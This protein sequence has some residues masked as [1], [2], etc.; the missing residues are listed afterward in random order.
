MKTILLSLFVFLSFS[1]LAQDLAGRKII[2][3]TL[4]FSYFSERHNNEGL[5]MNTSVLYGKIKEDHTYWALGGG[6]SY[7][8]G[9]INGNWSIGPGIE[10]GKFIQLIDKL[11]ISPYIGGFVQGRFGDDSGVVFNAYA[12]PLRFM[13]HL[14]E[15]FLL[16]AGFGSARV[17]SSFLQSGN[18]INLSASLD[19]SSGFGIFYTFK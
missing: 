8:S 13:Y 4:G 17:S 15:N 2:N 10:R 5:S 6:F 9:S 14:K 16:S 19:N 11:Y 1:S 7:Q 3:G 18:H 12:S